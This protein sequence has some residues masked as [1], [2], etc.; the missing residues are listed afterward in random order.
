[1]YKSE[2]KKRMLISQT[3]QQKNKCPR[4]DEVNEGLNSI[5]LRRTS[6]RKKPRHIYY[7]EKKKIRN[8]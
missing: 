7:L 2:E 5:A 8:R 1:M 6:K 4:S 3:K